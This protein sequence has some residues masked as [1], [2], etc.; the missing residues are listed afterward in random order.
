MSVPTITPVTTV[1]AALTAEAAKQK[2]LEKSTYVAFDKFEGG[3]GNNALTLIKNIGYALAYIVLKPKHHYSQTVLQ[4]KINESVD[5]VARIVLSANTVFSDTTNM[6][7]LG[8]RQTEAEGTCRQA[9]AAIKE[10]ADLVQKKAGTTSAVDF[11]TYAKTA[12]GLVDDRF[13]TKY[14]GARIGLANEM[15]Q[16]AFVNNMLSAF[17]GKGIKNISAEDFEDVLKGLTALYGPSK[18][19]SKKINA[20]IADR[21][22]QAFG[23]E[24]IQAEV[25]RIGSEENRAAATGILKGKFANNM[26]SAFVG[27]GIKNI[28]AE[29]FEDVLKGLTA[30]YGP[31]KKINAMITNRMKQAFGH[32]AIQAEIDRIGSEENRAAATAAIVAQ[33]NTKYT[34][35]NDELRILRGVRVGDKDEFDNGAKGKAYSGTLHKAYTALKEAD[36]ALKNV[37]KDV[38]TAIDSDPNKISDA[39]E[40]TDFLSELQEA[41]PYLK[42]KLEAALAAQ[43]EAQAACDGL[44]ARYVALVGKTYGDNKKAEPES[45]SAMGAISKALGNAKDVANKP[46]DERITFLNLVK[47]GTS[48]SSIAREIA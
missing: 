31:S 23:H 48:P 39:K 20:M 14:H 32:E 12:E 16:G 21:M 9:Q 38:I 29:D 26:L 35:L 28:S 41:A 43:G 11:A 36:T 33:L 34:S 24:A 3:W 18:K 19:S 46:I 45:T 37:T 7:E 44:R 17:V 40:L 2:L 1:P 22:Q 42:T 4:T 15:L 5:K 10:L 47:N 27:K 30:L 13:E 6:S 8:L 25:N